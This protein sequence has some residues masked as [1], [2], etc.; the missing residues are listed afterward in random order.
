MAWYHC[1][2]CG[3]ELPHAYYGGC[4]PCN[5]EK[6][7]QARAEAVAK[8]AARREASQS[9][10]A[11]NLPWEELTAEETQRRLGAMLG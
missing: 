3:K 5:C 10:Y 11:D 2:Y 4:A 7:Q 6:S 8:E 9:R 1:P